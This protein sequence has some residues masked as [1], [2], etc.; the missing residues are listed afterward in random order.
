MS[1]PC[2]PFTRGGN[3]RDHED[4]RSAGLLYLIR[5]LKE[6]KNPPEYL[7]L[8]NVLNFE[9]SE[10]RRLLVEALTLRGYLFEE[11]LVSPMDLN[12]PNDRLRY[13]LI[14]RKCAS[15]TSRDII[16]SF[17]EVYGN[18]DHLR[19]EKNTISDYLQPENDSDPTL[20]IPSRYLTDY[21]NYRHDIVHPSDTRSTTFTKAYGS[22]YIIGTGSFLQTKWL[23]LREYAKDDPEV[24][25]TL[26]LRWFAPEEVMALQGFP[27]NFKF[28]PG[29][30]RIQQYRLLGNS[31][32][33]T[34]V[35]VLLKRLV[36]ELGPRSDKNE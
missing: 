25:M 31:M 18:I 14:A 15:S 30:S 4:E 23:E 22:D 19:T 29:T 21:K 34:V 11:Y 6:M 26:G 3:Q 16:T 12:I 13:Y 36:L 35:G 32:N 28:A 20:Q 7:F 5:V 17:T 8:E 24:L 1:P 33:V 9:K 2:Q 10:C 27:T